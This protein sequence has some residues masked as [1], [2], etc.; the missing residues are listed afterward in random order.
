MAKQKP[1]KTK[2]I[3]N[4]NGITTRDG[5]NRFISALKGAK[6]ALR[7]NLTEDEIEKLVVLYKEILALDTRNIANIP[8]DATKGLGAVI[9]VH[10]DTGK[11]IRFVSLASP[12]YVQ[13][14]S[15]QHVDITR[16]SNKETYKVLPKVASSLKKLGTLQVFLSDI[17]SEVVDMTL[18]EVEKRFRANLEGL[19]EHFSEAQ[20]ISNTISEAEI[21]REKSVIKNAQELDK[22]IREL[23]RRDTVLRVHKISPEAIRDRAITYA[24]IG[25]ILERKMPMLVLMDVQSRI[26]PYEQPFYDTLREIPIPLL[27]PVKF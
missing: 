5:M 12:A 21:L 25:K 24:A 6:Q 14:S 7:R 16:G 2:Q 1:S 3:M 17:D 4:S 8:L 18:E 20:R 9:A 23:Q 22:S 26:Y 11:P 19:K 27:R 10:L 15:G 13:N